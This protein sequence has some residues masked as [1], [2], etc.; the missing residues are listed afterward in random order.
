MSRAAAPWLVEIPIAHRGLHGPG[1]PELSCAA[2]QRA[3]DA[4]IAV[5]ID[6]RLAA[7]RVAFVIHDADTERVTGVRKV[8]AETDTAD[9]RS[10]PVLDSSGP[11][12]IL[13]E[14]LA[15]LGGRVPLLVEL[16]HGVAADVIGPP[17]L[18][19]LRGYPGPWAV[20][21]FDPR[22]VRWFGRHAPQVVRGQIAG[23]LTGEGLGP[24]RRRLLES[25]AL[26]VVTRPDFLTYDVDALPSLAVS[27]WRRVLRCPLVVWTVRTERQRALAASSHA[28]LIFEDMPP[29]TTR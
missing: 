7:D 26:N 28:G 21:S 8:V 11:L 15:V 29:P 6:V 10:L 4:G 25:M 16:K 23:D 27:F 17:V 5:E 20:Q 14:A 9:L 22:I 2:L 12:L 1:A 24:V 3:V 13:D 19:C 18:A